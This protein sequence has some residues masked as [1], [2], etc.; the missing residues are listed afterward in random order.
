MHGTHAPSALSLHDPRYWP[1]GQV[2]M[3]QAEHEEPLR[4]KPA[5]HFQ[6]QVLESK[7]SPL[8]VKTALGGLLVQGW[9][10]PCAV[11]VHVPRY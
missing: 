1:A 10:E 11:L 5:A 7:G 2:D 9:Q 6:G 4:K 8:P 3:L